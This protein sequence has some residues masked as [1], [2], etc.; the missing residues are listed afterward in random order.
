MGTIDKT[1]R[2]EQDGS[3]VDQINTLSII[4]GQSVEVRSPVADTFQ[5]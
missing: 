5:N 4:I 2:K 3:C 1:L